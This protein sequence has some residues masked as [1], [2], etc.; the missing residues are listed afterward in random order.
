[1]LVNVTSVYASLYDTIQNY[2]RDKVLLFQGMRAF[3]KEIGVSA[4]PPQKG[5]SHIQDKTIKLLSKF[6][7]PYWIV[8]KATI[9]QGKK[10]ILWNNKCGEYWVK[11]LNSLTLRIF[12]N[13]TIP[14][15]FVKLHVKGNNFQSYITTS[16]FTRSSLTR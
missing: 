3:S 5:V 16:H 4:L 12:R 15:C 8:Q 13:F 11:K 2:V 7:F 6:F 1:M 10:Y 9:F 14:K